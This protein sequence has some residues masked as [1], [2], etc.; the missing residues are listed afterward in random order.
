[1]S[2]V[3]AGSGWALVVFGIVVLRAR[4]SLVADAEHELRSAV[5]AV[6]LAAERMR[7]AGAT[8]AFASLVALQLDRME[9]ALVDLS[10]AREPRPWAHEP[11]RAGPGRSAPRIDAGRLSQVVANLVDN[12][13]EHGVGPVEVR[14]NA[15]GSGARLEI[16]NRNAK[17]AGAAGAPPRESRPIELDELVTKRRVGRGRG[18]AIAARAARDLGGSLRVDSGEEVT[19][20]TLE[21]P[22]PGDGQ[23]SR[24]A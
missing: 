12:A 6:S 10:R 19:A 3:L 11:V 20:A 4:L 5:A 8:R 14:W 18:L 23:D 17:A 7:R 1:V 24:A 9:A 15:T 2:W 21:L 13:A 22:A 16:R